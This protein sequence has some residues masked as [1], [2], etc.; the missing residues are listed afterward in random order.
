MVYL[1]C[2]STDAKGL[3]ITLQLCNYGMKGQKIIAI[4][5]LLIP[6]T[7]LLN[8]GEN[9]IFNFLESFIRKNVPSCC[10]LILGKTN[11][12]KLLDKSINLFV[13]GGNLLNQTININ[14]EV[15]DLGVCSLMPSPIR[16]Q[17]AIYKVYLFSSFEE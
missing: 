4:V 14:Q 7:A 2:N 17:R 8:E 6:A 9:I 5:E 12:Q 10:I 11:S 15:S 1:V 16:L 13:F 3:K